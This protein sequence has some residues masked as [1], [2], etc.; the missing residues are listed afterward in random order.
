MFG[1]GTCNSRYDPNLLLLSGQSLLHLYAMPVL[2]C[3][4]LCCAVLC[5]A[6]LCCAAW[7]VPPGRVLAAAVAQ[8][9]DGQQQGVAK[10]RP[11]AHHPTP[12]SQAPL[13]P[14]TPQRVRGTSSAAQWCCGDAAQEVGCLGRCNSKS[15]VGPGL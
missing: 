3:A 15:P 9:R 1:C 5:C 2:C 10:G 12:L 8:T 4:V 13:T 11:T 7:I 6:V 14:R